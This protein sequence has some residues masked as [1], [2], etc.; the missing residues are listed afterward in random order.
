MSVVLPFSKSI[1]DHELH[2]HAISYV[3]VINHVWRVHQIGIWSFNRQFHESIEKMIQISLNSHSTIDDNGS[4]KNEV[5]S[6]HMFE[7]RCY[8]QPKEIF[9]KIYLVRSSEKFSL[10]IFDQNGQYF[11]QFTPPTSNA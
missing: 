8:E 10:R 3:K 7:K 1:L 2:K 4:I 5:S 9:F 11:V 6:W